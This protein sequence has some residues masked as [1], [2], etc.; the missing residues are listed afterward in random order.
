MFP[1]KGAL[2]AATE[3]PSGC[4]RNTSA[5]DTSIPASSPLSRD[6]C[7]P[8]NP[9]LCDNRP[10]N[11]MPP[12]HPRLLCEFTL[13]LLLEKHWF[14]FCKQ[15]SCLN[16]QG[17]KLTPNRA[18]FL[19]CFHTSERTCPRPVPL[20][21][22]PVLL[23]DQTL[24]GGRRYNHVSCQKPRAFTS[25]PSSFL[26]KYLAPLNRAMHPLCLL[27]ENLSPDPGA[28]AGM[29][30]SI[31]PRGCLLLQKE[32]RDQGPPAR[33]WG[34]T[35]SVPE[36]PGLAGGAGVLTMSLP[37]EGPCGPW[38][39][40]HLG[41]RGT[42]VRGAA[43]RMQR[44][45]SGSTR[46]GRIRALTP[47]DR[48]H[49]WS[50]RGPCESTAVIK[51]S[52]P[53]E[54]APG[55]EHPRR[56]PGVSGSQTRTGLELCP[57]AHSRLRGAQTLRR[58]SATRHQGAPYSPSSAIIL[59]TADAWTRLLGLWASLSAE[60]ALLTGAALPGVGGP[61]GVSPLAASTL[62]GPGRK[63]PRP[64]AA[65]HDAQ[66]L[67]QR[68]TDQAQ[69][70]T[71][72]PADRKGDE[73]G[74]GE[75]WN[76]MRR[77]RGKMKTRRVN[78]AP[79]PP[80]SRLE[81]PGNLSP[82]L[83][84][85][86]P[87]D[88]PCKHSARPCSNPRTRSSG[89]GQ[90]SRTANGPP[91]PA[92]LGGKQ[93]E[94]RMRWGP[95][96]GKQD[97][98]PTCTL[99]S[100]PG[101]P[102]RRYL[103]TSAPRE[104][105]SRVRRGADYGQ[106]TTQPFSSDIETLTPPREFVNIRAGCPRASPEREARAQPRFLG[107][108]DKLATCSAASLPVLS[109]PLASRQR[110]RGVGGWPRPATRGAGPAPGLQGCKVVA[111]EGTLRNV[112]PENQAGGHTAR[113]QSHQEDPLFPV[114]RLSVSLAAELEARPSHSGS[115]SIF[116][117]SLPGCRHYSQPRGSSG[118]T[119]P[120]GGPASQAPI[121][122]S[123]AAWLSSRERHDVSLEMKLP[124]T[125]NPMDEHHTLKDAGVRRWKKPRSLAGLMEPSFNAS[126][127]C[128]PPAHLLWRECAPRCQS[129]PVGAFLLQQV[130]ASLPGDG[131][132]ACL[133]CSLGTRRNRPCVHVHEHGGTCVRIR[134]RVSH[135]LENVLTAFPGEGTFL[136]LLEGEKEATRRAGRALTRPRALGARG[137]ETAGGLCW[138][139]SPPVHGYGGRRDLRGACKE[140]GQ[141]G[142]RERCR[143]AGV[144][145]CVWGTKVGRS[146][147]LVWPHSGACA[148]SGG[149]ARR[150]RCALSLVMTVTFTALGRQA[151][152]F[153]NRPH[154]AIHG[155]RTLFISQT[156]KAA[157]HCV[158][159][160]PR[161]PTPCVPKQE[162]WGPENS[163]LGLGSATCQ[164][165][166]LEELIG[167]PGAAA[168]LW[169]LHETYVISRSQQNGR[170]T[171]PDFP[172][173]QAQCK[174]TRVSENAFPKSG[175]VL[176]DA[177]LRE[178]LICD[179]TGTSAFC[180]CFSQQPLEAACG[181]R[182]DFWKHFSIFL[183]TRTI[184]SP[185][186]VS[187]FPQTLSPYLLHR[188]ASHRPALPPDATVPPSSLDE[189]LPPPTLWTSPWAHRFSSNQSQ[190]FGAPCV[191][192]CLVTVLG[193]RPT[194]CVLTGGCHPPAQPSE[195][196]FPMMPSQGSK[197]KE[198]TCHLPEEAQNMAQASHTSTR[199]RRGLEGH[200]CAVRHRSK[201][202]PPERG[203]ANT[204]FLLSIARNFFTEE[205]QRRRNSETKQHLDVCKLPV[206]R[207]RFA[208]HVFY[209][210]RVPPAESGL[211]RGEHKAQAAMGGARVCG[212]RQD[213]ETPLH[214]HGTKLCAFVSSTRAAHTTSPAGR[215]CT[216]VIELGRGHPRGLCGKRHGEPR[217]DHRG[218]DAATSTAVRRTATARRWRM[219]EGL[220]GS[221][222]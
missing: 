127:G 56:P 27:W 112:K 61:Q 122:P 67:R 217:C 20:M 123:V 55:P 159:L 43:R 84:E 11:S 155:L 62:Q 13:F 69:A 16:S 111:K 141:G 107:D 143:Q 139:G 99:Q 33:S 193:L 100:A 38:E 218:R 108:Q 78:T 71:P 130:R 169:S 97:W 10:R 116:T 48:I 68:P 47:V 194:E 120:G 23:P 220:Q 157:L 188:D 9:T 142:G 146:Q 204:S 92:Q 210:T 140:A 35:T 174:T 73:G 4:K 173:S 24:P 215:V 52:C 39:V 115:V 15:D 110:A 176:P 29:E 26:G 109:G 149:P 179:P 118:R 200:P 162:S 153:Q 6:R 14:P 94:E 185:L 32:G 102:K 18:V 214:S 136:L 49:C 37:T 182:L 45:W 165:G 70:R 80:T 103:L 216:D 137:K 222:T 147:A 152:V 42:K 59:A 168:F 41:N 60:A 86:K 88:K 128:S 44:S 211:T 34:G 207:S 90:S 170:A 208:G 28:A 135:G 50:H 154:L 81:V 160:L 209:K 198:Y 105:M 93:K 65:I 76:K 2:P 8:R 199:Q 171:T 184:T 148:G 151:L 181:I 53:A 66:V 213:E 54:P 203:I 63:P 192:H 138:R 58:G 106:G 133:L 175:P 91:P 21:T 186:L 197:C 96:K 5:D 191:Q 167:T 89:A 180:P 144:W 212:T 57:V 125:F 119:A 85:Q 161:T 166:D 98:G 126:V 1:E 129:Q 3:V 87:G 77:E 183:F 202:G 74:E 17:G 190:P 121:L 219:R 113:T 158:V 19:E 134:N 114:S 132:D 187:H 145:E 31:C 163:L 75:M 205:I 195:P 72:P 150:G 51:P 189:P 46:S 95:D 196:P 22:V 30:G 82:P 104:S 131:R 164:P 124:S 25:A 172:L 221:P 206:K 79:L 156:S 178:W 12:M 83:T 7:H 177:V 36:A 64:Q 101:K 40:G 201:A 117:S